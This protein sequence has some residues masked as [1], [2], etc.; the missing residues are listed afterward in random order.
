MIDGDAVARR[1]LAL[2]DALREL[3][4]PSASDPRALASDAV[5]RAAVERWL[6]IAVE[7]CIDV[8]DHVVAAQGWT[9]V[10]SARAS[11]A[12]LAAHG[13]IPA[14]LAGRLGD[15]A[16]LRNILVHDY[17]A[18]DLVRLAGVVRDDL[19]D[20][21]TFARLAAGWVDGDATSP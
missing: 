10:D 8:A 2:G 5:L 4:R 21:R 19:G 14:D 16:A 7:A 12:R 6:Q 15:A 3:E 17:V 18:V 9:P 1:L 20:L 13:H 11:F